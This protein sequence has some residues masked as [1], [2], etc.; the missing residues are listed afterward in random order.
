MSNCENYISEE[1]IRALKESEQHIEHVARSRDSSGSKA[2]SV[3][4]TIRGESVT[5]RTLDGLEKLYTDKIE[6][7]GYQQM[8]DYAT[9]INI[10]ARDQIVFYDGSWYMYR[11]ELPHVTTGATLPEDGGIWSDTNPNGSWVDVGDAS[12]RSELENG[13]GSLIG[14][15]NDLTLKDKLSE[16][17]SVRDYGVVGDGSDES[18]KMQLAI[19]SGIV[20]I[21][22]NLSVSFSDITIPKGTEFHFGVNSTLISTK[23]DAIKFE[24]NLECKLSGIY[25]KNATILTIMENVQSSDYDIAHVIRF[26][27][28]SDAWY[29]ANANNPNELGFQGAALK[30]KSVIGSEIKLESGVPFD[31]TEGSLVFL[32]K[33]KDTH[34]F[35]GKIINSE[36]G[37]NYIFDS[38]GCSD[39]Y[40]HRTVFDFDG[41]GG[42]RHGLSFNVHY[43]S[44]LQKNRVGNGNIFFGYGSDNCTV[45]DSI[46][47]GGKHG[48]AQVTAFAGARNILSQRNTYLT[49]SDAEP[50]IGLYF[51]GK[52]VSCRSIDDKFTGGKYGF[53]SA[54]G[55]QGFEVIRPV[56]SSQSQ[57]SIFCQDSQ[58][59]SVINT[60]S[61]ITVHQNN[62]VGCI[63]L[64]GCDEYTVINDAKTLNAGGGYIF[65]A[66]NKVSDLYRVSIKPT[67]S[68]KGFGDININTPMTQFKIRDC[69]T[70][71]GL[72]VYYQGGFSN[73]GRVNSNS[74]TKGMTLHSLRYCNVN[75]N[76][77]DGD[78]GDYAIRFT[79][80]S[81]FCK[82]RRN[83]LSGAT[84]AFHLPATQQQ[85]FS[86]ALYDDNEIDGT[87][88]SFVNNK[89]YPTVKPVLGVI[90][91]EEPPANFFLPVTSQWDDTAALRTVSGYRHKGLHTGTANDWVT[92][93]V[94]E[95]S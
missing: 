67:L 38:Q 24:K 92:V 17:I 28:S 12:L 75:D 25:P 91:G 5:N 39:I 30:I 31:L 90:S 80:S 48:D 6:S 93:N 74:A 43:R 7:L 33:S 36:D 23:K 22:D 27:D 15:G 53:Y 76:A 54:Y 68:V 94:S 81:R 69:D 84:N 32:S 13:D 11:G 41:N 29:I 21:P 58:R 8:G 51:G 37:S 89:I 40:F 82:A 77:I 78:G 86:I 64:R 60:T 4:D 35:G 3:T 87:I 9:G 83:K 44:V 56:C 19:D 34:F 61:N 50:S 16:L 72:I 14:I 52:T 88:S 85:Y 26:S 46:F 18:V 73:H 71:G 63:V 1:D 49:E 79:G 47:I 95:S 2:L 66:Y 57:A 10:T 55:A 45:I 70:E 59:F 65:S 62:T 20:R 42:C